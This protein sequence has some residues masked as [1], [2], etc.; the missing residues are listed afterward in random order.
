[1]QTSGGASCRRGNSI[2]PIT[3]C[4]TRGEI[5]MVW[6]V[7]TKH[8]SEGFILIS[9]LVASVCLGNRPYR[10]LHPIKPEFR[11]PR[12]SEREKTVSAARAAVPRDSHRPALEE[13]WSTLS[14]LFKSNFPLSKSK[15]ASFFTKKTVPKIASASVAILHTQN[16]WLYV[17][18][19]MVNVTSCSPRTWSSSPV[20]VKGVTLARFI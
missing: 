6:V 19:F 10:F 13:S 15:L 11:L 20:T 12:P 17:S 8:G 1:M 7:F 18:P 2:R 5:R 4:L 9:D 14:A 3:I 16:T